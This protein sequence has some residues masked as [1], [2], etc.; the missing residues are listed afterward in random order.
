MAD[1]SPSAH[2]PPV[3][4]PDVEEMNALL[5]QYEF[6]KL[7]AFGGMGAVYKAMQASLER[8][9]AVKI[10]PPAFGEDPA[11]AERFKI[12]ARAMAKLNHTNVVA[13]YDFGITRAGHFY[14]VMEWVQGNTLH[15]LIQKGAVPVKRVASLMMQL[16]DALQFAHSHQILH[17]DIK[18]GNLMVNDEERLKVADFGLARPITG[19]AEENPLGT[20]DYASPEI[21]SNGAV[22]QRADIFAAG[23]VLY[24]LL[25]GRVPGKTRRSVTEFSPVSKRWDDIIARATDPDPLKRYPDALEFRAHIAAALTMAKTN[26]SAPATSAP[27]AASTHAPAPSRKKQPLLLAG[28]G[29]AAVFIGLFFAFRPVEEEKPAKRPKKVKTAEEAPQAEIAKTTPKEPEPKKEPEAPP[30]TTPAP[31]P[32]KMAEAKPVEPAPE[33]KKTEPAAPAPAMAATTPPAP[34][35]TIQE[36]LAKLESDDPELLTTLVGIEAQW[37]A[38]AEANP[39]PALQDL[40][41]KYIPALQRSL[42]PALTSDQREALL[43]EISTIANKQTLPTPQDT[44]PA[45][46]Q[47]LRQTYQSQAGVIQQK[48]AGATRTLLSASSEALMR[49]AQERTAKG[50]AVGA[51]RAEAVATALKKIDARPTLDAVRGAL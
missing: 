50:D 20:P 9:V 21:T 27:V 23:V 15:E 48:A 8:P 46:L 11:F 5:P 12:E 14:L 30:A 42:T 49:L 18:P 43:T 4:V 33:P 28:F 3:D 35:P 31:E 34:A 37:E 17:R 32:P 40:A 10:L 24:E 26:D 7:A 13:V 45:V 16:C 1:D 44:W 39:G 25:T 29:I 2:T 38:S 36:L 22:D 6:E 19:E 51:K 41:G 47:Q